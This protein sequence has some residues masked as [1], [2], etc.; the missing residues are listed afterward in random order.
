MSKYRIDA[1][2]TLTSPLHVSEVES[3]YWNAN[4]GR[5]TENGG[6]ITTRT[7]RIPFATPATS[8]SGDTEQAKNR[9]IAFLPGNS[10]RG[11]LRRCAAETIFDALQARQEKCSLELYHVLMCG[12][13]SRT[14]DKSATILDCVESGKNPFASLFGGGPKMLRGHLS[15]GNAFPITPDTVQ[16]MLVPDHLAEL[17]TANFVTAV[18]IDSPVDDIMRPRGGVPSILVDPEKEISAWLA[19]LQDSSDRKSRGEEGKKVSLA[20]PH[21]REVIIPGV[22]LHSDILLDSSFGGDAAFGL[23]VVALARFANRA[24]IGGGNRIGLGR[25]VLNATAHAE[26]GTTISLLH[27]AGQGFTPNLSEEK[28]SLAVA[29]WEEFAKTLTAEKLERAFLLNRGSSSN[30]GA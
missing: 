30:K 8:A 2:L 24:Q 27:N 16:A 17:A 5:W 13:H 7:K 1:V 6:H 28:V 10:L 18:M 20:G 12:A 22:R 26:D 14:P 3:G 15:I 29:A 11:V 4:E 21:G 23:F 19:K 9:F 25:F